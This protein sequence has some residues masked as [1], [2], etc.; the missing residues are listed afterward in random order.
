MLREQAGDLRARPG[1]LGPAHWAGA[2]RAGLDVGGED[3]REQP[4]PSLARRGCIV[5]VAEQLELIAASGRG[6][7]RNRIWRR[8][9]HDKAPA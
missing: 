4:G 8:R 9:G 1:N 6:P 2:A 3:V 7:V 5:L